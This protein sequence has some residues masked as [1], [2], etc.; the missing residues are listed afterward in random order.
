MTHEAQR[1]AMAQAFGIPY[2]VCM[3]GDS[4]K[5]HRL[6][7]NEHNFTPMAEMPDEQQTKAI[8]KTIGKWDDSL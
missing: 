8:L 6:G 1:T 7:G 4:E 5:S 3:W 2:D